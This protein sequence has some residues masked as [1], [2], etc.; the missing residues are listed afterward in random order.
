[1]MTEL[2]ESTPQRTTFWQMITFGCGTEAD[3]RNSRRF[4]IWCTAWALAIIGSTWIVETFEGLPRI[5][6]VLIA[7][8]PNGFA[9]AALIAYMRFLRMTDE[10]QRKIQIEG[11]A[12]GFGVGW[13]FAIG[14]LVLQSAGAPALSVTAMILVMTAG[15]IVGN[16]LAIRYYR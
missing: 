11:L 1:M 2:E 4:N 5:A 6:A 9:I 7:L 3:R 13:I 8:A 16:V 15:W 10:L 14:Y 12:V